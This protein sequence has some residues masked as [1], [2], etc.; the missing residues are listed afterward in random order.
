MAELLGLSIRGEEVG[1]TFFTSY[2]LE[3]LYLT[4][5]LSPFGVLGQPYAVNVEF[6]GYLGVLPLLLALLAPVLR[7]DFRTW[8]FLF[9]AFVALSLALGKYNPL[10]EW[11]Y[12]IPVFN[13]F[14]VP[15]RFLF[16][17]AFAV[18]FLAATGFEELCRR[19]RNTSE[20]GWISLGLGVT[21]G[22]A[23]LFVVNLA[24]T[25][26]P[27]FWMDVW[28][29]LPVFLVLSGIGVIVAARLRLATQVVFGVMVLGLTVF[30]LFTFSAPFLAT[31]T[32]T[33]TLAE[34]LAVPRTV[35]QMDNVQVAYRVY[36]N[37][38]PSVTRTAMRA[39]LL[40]N[41]ALMYGKESAS[42]YMHSLGLQKNVEYIG[43]MSSAMRNLINI[44]Y[45]LFP[46][47][48]LPWDEPPSAIAEPEIGLSLYHLRLQP[49]IPPTRV[50]RVEIISYTDQSAELPD[51]FS[52]GELLLTSDSGRLIALP[53][54]LGKETGDWAYDGIARLG[55]VSHS[56]PAN[57]LAFPAYL[58]SVGRE[59]Q[60]HKYVAHYD[61]ATE[62][63]PLL[64]TAVGV[65][66]FL[67]D[68]GLT[69]ER[70]SLSDES[71]HVV[72]LAALLDR[73]DLA[74]VLRS[75]TAAMWENR[76]V[77]PRAFV[78]HRAEIVK[79]DQVLTRMKQPDF[80]PDQVVLLSEG[81]S[82]EDTEETK[83]EAI[84]AATI[85][86][87][88]PE[89]VVV[90]VKADKPGYLVLTD[91]WYP[92]WVAWVDGQR[93]PIYRADYIFR[94]VP[95]AAGQHSVVFEYH[96]ASFA[97]GAAISGLSTVVCVIVAIV[98]FFRSI[99]PQ[100]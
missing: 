97:W 27:E 9:F 88:K 41:I 20:T 79:D 84:A 6:W 75:H 46:L 29:L 67:P 16:L 38:I 81:R 47:E 65:R 76:D 95:L 1:K 17:V 5:F 25:Q 66:S 89:R 64:V 74:L 21:A 87:Y 85:A 98:G 22:M 31:L 53:I 99:V 51:G 60:G 93:A 8:F 78:V 71:G 90:N 83:K 36:S 52:A 10:Y 14:R 19:L 49:G 45:Y 35:Q 18:S 3:P 37:K 30:D 44:R 69:V 63:A 28:G 11:L 55:P 86:E 94:A 77:L 48:R 34:L 13:R 40:T 59:F 57:T 33:A 32:R 39:A 92:G 43:E 72:S 73:N 82:L 91:T 7:R 2:S 50:A 23:S 54:R 26:P 68:A 56:K 4:Q 12:N 15:A 80:R 62:A 70:V 42:G 58:S 24:Y 96:P 100:V 61:V